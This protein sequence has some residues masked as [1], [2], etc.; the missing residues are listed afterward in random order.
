MARYFQ[1][2]KKHKIA[3]EA[4]KEVIQSDP[5]HVKAYNAMGVSYDYLG[6]F[7]KAVQS[8][9]LALKINPNLDY[10]HNNLG[11]AY[12]LHEKYDDAIYA[13]QKAIELNDRNKR[14]RNNLALLYV[15]KERYDLAIQQLKDIEGGSHAGETVAKLAQKLGKKD[16]EKQIISVL[17]R[18]ALEK[19]LVRETKTAP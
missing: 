6:D 4:L 17:E 13:F 10:V 16:F 9:K 8:Y 11:Y 14:Y 15:M 7:K 5:S 2:K 12:L 19:A 1:K 18:M 3:L